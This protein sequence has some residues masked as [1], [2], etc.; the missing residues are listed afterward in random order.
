MRLLNN[1]VLISAIIISLLFTSM[2]QLQAEV[3][4]SMAV[5]IQEYQPTASME[6][7]QLKRVLEHK[8]VRQRLRDYGLDEA[9]VANRLSTLSA[10][11][12]HILA[13]ASNKLLAAGDK[14]V[15]NGDDDEGPSLLTIVAAVTLITLVAILIYMLIFKD[16]KSKGMT[17][18]SD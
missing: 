15:I 11:Q 12:I 17:L 9:E 4:G 1:P 5:K 7:G 10:A 3:V 2:A 14:V 8:I 13:H 6:I 18:F 16:T